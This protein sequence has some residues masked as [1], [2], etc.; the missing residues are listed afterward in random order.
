LATVLTGCV[1]ESVWD[2]ATGIDNSKAAPEGF[3]YDDAMSSKTSLAVY[4]DGQKA[5]AAGAQSFMVQLTDKDN[6]DKGNSWDSKLT[7]VLT[8]DKENFE[9]AIFSGLKEYDLYYVRV[10]AN[11]PNSVYSPWVYLSRENGAPALYQIGHG[12]V[13]LVPVVSLNPLVKDIVVSWTYSEG[14]TKYK[15]EWK[16][17]SE[18]TWSTPVETT[19]TTYTI[20]GLSPETSYD[21]R[22]TSVTATA[23]NVSEVATATTKEQPPFPMEIATA[24]QWM[25]FINGEFIG[26]ANNGADDVVTLTADLDFTG[27]QYT[28]EAVFKGVIN[29]NGK[30]IKNLTTAIPFFK[31]VTSVKDLTFDATCALTTSVA[32]KYAMVAKVSTGAFTNITNN[33][34]VTVALTE[35]PGAEDALIAAGIVA[36]AGADVTNCTNNGN[37]TITSVE[38]LEAS[39]AGGICGYAST[40]VSN[41]TNNGNVSQTSTHYIVNA[42]VTYKGIAKVPQHTGG[43]VAMTKLE[44]VVENCTNT[45]TV[46][47]NM[48]AIEKIGQSAGTNRIRVGG[49]VGAARGDIIGCTNKGTVECF[50]RTSTRAAQKATCSKNYSVSPGGITGGMMDY[51]SAEDIGMNVKNCVNEGAV[52]VDADV[53]GNNSTVG[54]IVSHPGYEDASNTNSI[55]N[56]I[57]RGDI[58][59]TGAGKFRVGGINGGMANVLGC[60]NYGTIKLATNNKGA[61]AGSCVAGISGYM[62]KNMKH[63]NNKNFGDIIEDTDLVHCVSGLVANWNNLKATYGVGCVVKC[64][65]TTKSSLAKAGM[66][67][68]Y[69]ENAEMQIGTA[70]APVKVSGSFNGVAIDASNVAS[71]AM[72]S[73]SKGIMNVV[74][75]E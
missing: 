36:E 17:T 54:G 25:D 39:L 32:G 51:G 7:Q 48:S 24:Q 37:V 40:K 44:S 63:E 4:W 23:N 5:V 71:T 19:E 9:S 6:M 18:T 12:A 13:A 57:N 28:T 14:A 20:T 72:G 52:V 59:V 42:W 22:V 34:N 2:R 73:S 33:G 41:C 8:I 3:T 46:T 60:E 58:T 47:L 16:K 56:C 74:F 1:K 49:I 15:V 43:I 35:A 68:G 66:V 27:I 38:G 69:G 62:G 45:G 75:G 70:E 55:E 10:R 64:N 67:G 21:V 61:N 65:V 53:D 26:L 11:Y 50:A 30:T 31:E 29:G